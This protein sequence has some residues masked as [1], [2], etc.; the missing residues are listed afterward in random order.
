MGPFYKAKVIRLNSGAK[1]IELS[2]VI[3][4]GHPQIRHKSDDGNVVLW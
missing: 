1:V 4:R 2:S 3:K